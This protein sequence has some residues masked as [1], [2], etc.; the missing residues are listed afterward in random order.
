[1]LATETRALEAESAAIPTAK[2]VAVAV[3]FAAALAIAAQIRIPLPFTPVPITLQT[4]TLYLGA[5]W[6][7]PRAAMSGLTLYVAAALAGVP[8][9]S[10]YRGGLAAFTGATGGYI[11][12]WFVAAFVVGRLL[13]GAKPLFGRSAAAMAVGSAIILSCGALHLGLLLGT[14]PLE[15]LLLGVAPFL[16]GDILKILTASAL[17]RRW[18]NPLEMR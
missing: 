10:G 4:L 2:V 14:G 9:M 1:M 3:G 5:A 12:G 13:A 17:V 15:T 18:P 7:A 11:V 16:P 8:V 6:L